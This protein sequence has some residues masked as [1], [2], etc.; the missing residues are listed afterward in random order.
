MRSTTGYVGAVALLARYPVKSMRGEQLTA[1]DVDQQGIVGDRQWAVYTPDGGIGSGKTSKRFRRIDGLLGYRATFDESAGPVPLIESPTG[2]RFRADEPQASELLS[3]AFDRPL[4][5][6]REAG[7]RHHDESGL[8]LVTTAAL[9]RLSELLGE[10]VEVARF[11]PNL[12]LDVPGTGFVEDD[13]AGHELRLGSDVVVRLGTGMSR[14]V[15]VDMAQ[16]DLGP[17]GRILKLLAREHQLMLGLKVEVVR[18][19]IVRQ[20]D[21][22]VL[23]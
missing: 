15:M 6:G 23:D 20:G 2:Q 13:W 21:P 14:C 5:L 19:G 16:D 7:V 8:H 18:G 22:A 10:T 9:R 1:A 3:A 12:I 17:D 11:R 4:R